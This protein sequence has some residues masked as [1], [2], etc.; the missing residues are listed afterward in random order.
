MGTV[1]GRED[2]N[3]AKRSPECLAYKQLPELGWQVMS[4][5]WNVEIAYYE[6]QLRGTEK[7]KARR[8][9]S[10]RP[11]RRVSECACVVQYNRAPPC[12]F[13]T[14]CRYWTKRRGY[15]T[16]VECAISGCVRL[17]AWLSCVALRCVA[18]RCVQE[19]REKRPG[20]R[21]FS[22]WCPWRGL[23]PLTDRVPLTCPFPVGHGH[24]L[25]R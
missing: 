21:F 4:S 25:Q 17:A 14:L 13:P 10:V 5:V 24:L 3:K 9:E 18:L 8:R 2:K 6:N 15:S 12:P 7:K 16:M 23:H 1:R 20:D 22:V 19:E 11:Q